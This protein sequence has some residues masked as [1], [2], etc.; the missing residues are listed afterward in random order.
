M[1][2]G[3]K[4]RIRKVGPDT[5]EATLVMVGKAGT[6]QLVKAEAKALAPSKA[7]AVT[8]AADIA[9][10]IADN[11]V[12]AAV[13]PP[14]TKAGIAAAV[15]V[16]DVVKAGGPVGATLAKFSGKGARRLAKVLGF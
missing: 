8:R 13:L 11:P 9:N 2:D 3:V 5:Y 1:M 14:G 4:V 10:Q 7:D 16:A 6:H 12:L 15:K